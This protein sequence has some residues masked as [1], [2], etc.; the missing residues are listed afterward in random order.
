MPF[1]IIEKYVDTEIQAK[2]PVFKYSRT[3]Y[4]ENAQITKIGT[5][6]AGDYI[7]KVYSYVLYP[8]PMLM[9]YTNDDWNNGTPFYTKF[10]ASWYETPKKV[11]QAIEQQEAQAEQQEIET[12]GAIPFY[13]EKYGT[14]LFIGIAAVAVISSLIKKDWKK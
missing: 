10:E 14:K 11:T 12:K 9:F 4:K 7:G 2:V 1:E 5:F 8:S 13:I 3:G 6:K